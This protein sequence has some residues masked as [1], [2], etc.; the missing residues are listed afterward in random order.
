MKRALRA[1]LALDT[2]TRDLEVVFKDGTLARLDLLITSSIPPKNSDET[3]QNT[4]NNQQLLINDKWLS[5]ASSHEA[6]PCSLSN[7]VTKGC[8]SVDFFS[9]S[10]IIIELYEMILLELSGGVGAEIDSRLRLRVSEN[11]RQMPCNVKVMQTENASELLVSWMDS[12]SDR[13]WKLHRLDRIGQVTL[14]NQSSCA[15]GLDDELLALCKSCLS[16]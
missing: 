5:F 4:G 8:L 3:V 9:C 11:V 15:S 13:D 7:E 1:V 10:H 2:R 14:H 16:I 12:E 6:A